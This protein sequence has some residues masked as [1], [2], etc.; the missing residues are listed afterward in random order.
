MQ[1]FTPRPGEAGWIRIG[2]VVALAACATVLAGCNLHISDRVEARDDWKR[3][4]EVASGATLEIRNANGRINVEA[5]DGSKIDVLAV[6]VVRAASEEVAKSALE[7][8]EIEA[9]ASA[10]RVVLDTSTRTVGL[11]IGISRSADF[12]IKVPKGVGV[13]IRSSNGDVRVAGVS[14]PLRATSSNG[15]ITATNIDA[16]AELETT[17]GNIDLDVVRVPEAGLSCETTNGAATVTFNRDAKA[18]LSVRTVNGS[19]DTSGLELSGEPSRGRLEATIGGG[20][21]TVRVETTNGA[22][23]LRGR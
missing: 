21:P 19:V 18:R 2:R 3:T 11:T 7:Q 4:Y 22:V 12:T 14:G 17:N 8:F 23:R 5:G 20:G 10:D 15:N 6:R 13:T 9:S 16:A 1:L